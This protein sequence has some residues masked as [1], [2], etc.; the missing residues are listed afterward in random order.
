MP[1]KQKRSKARLVEIKGCVTEHVARGFCM[2]PPEEN[3]MWRELWVKA[4]NVAVAP[5]DIR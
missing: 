2:V 3:T 4:V 5:A 1:I